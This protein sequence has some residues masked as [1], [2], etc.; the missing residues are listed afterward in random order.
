MK[1]RR[2]R[3]REMASEEQ[4]DWLRVVLETHPESPTP[5]EMRR[6]GIV[7]SGEWQD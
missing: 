6:L 7:Q 4:Q 2:R 5:V 1:R 3:N